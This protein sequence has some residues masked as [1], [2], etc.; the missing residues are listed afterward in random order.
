VVGAVLA[1]FVGW[2]AGAP[3]P[4][5]RRRALGPAALAGRLAIG[6]LAYVIVYFVAGFLAFPFLADFYAGRAMPGLGELALV[7]VFRGSVFT[8]I[9]AA[10]VAWTAMSLRHVALSVGLTLSVLGGVVPLM[11][12][13]AFMPTSVRLVHLVEV[14]VSNVLFGLFVGWLFSRVRDAAA[15]A[16]A[17][18]A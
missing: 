18:P 12:P 15:S 10:I 2:Q 16:P 7:A 6:S 3:A 11:A 4:S 1:A 14:G 8:T 17:V 9:A 13:N 5:D